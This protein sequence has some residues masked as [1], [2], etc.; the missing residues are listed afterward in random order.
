MSEVH[1]A[2]PDQADHDDLPRRGVVD[3]PATAWELR[4]EIRGA[5]NAGGFLEVG[6]DLPPVPGVVAERDDVGSGVQHP[7]GLLR[8]EADHH[9]V[10][11]VDGAETDVV[12]L[13]KPRQAVLQKGEARRRDDIAYGQYI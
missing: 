10:F 4:R 7:F 5:E 12:S 6:D 8:L 9:G 11:T 13:F 2:P 1:A 3:P